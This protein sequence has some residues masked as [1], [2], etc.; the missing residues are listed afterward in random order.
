MTETDSTEHWCYGVKS[1]AG[2][3]GHWVLFKL[4]SGDTSLPTSGHTC[5]DSSFQ[6]TKKLQKEDHKRPKDE[7][8]S[9]VKKKKKGDTFATL[10]VGV[11]P[12]GSLGPNIL[13]LKEM[14]GLDL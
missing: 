1:M 6:P 4:L 8:K 11:G 7:R 9:E 5:G 13:A 3:K 2:G 14:N 10:Q 12:I